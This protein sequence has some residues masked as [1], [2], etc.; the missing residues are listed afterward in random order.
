ML[1]LENFLGIDLTK[2][3][4]ENWLMEG[5]E[6]E[7]NGEFVKIYTTSVDCEELPFFYKCTAKVAGCT[8]T[9]FYFDM[10]FDIMDAHDVAFTIERDLFHNGRYNYNDSISKFGKKLA[11]EFG[12]IVWKYKDITIELR[13]IDEIACLIVWTKYDNSKNIKQKETSSDYIWCIGKVPLTV[14]DLD[15][16]QETFR[17]IS[18]YVVGA[19][20]KDDKL[21]AFE[22]NQRKILFEFISPEIRKLIREGNIVGM[23]LSPDIDESNPHF[24]QISMKTMYFP[25]NDTVEED[26]LE[27]EDELIERK[28]SS[29]SIHYVVNNNDVEKIIKYKN[30]H[31]SV[32]GFQYHTDRDELLDNI[33]IGTELNLIPEPTNPYDPQAIAVYWKETLI[34]YIPRTDIPAIAVN[35]SN[36][37]GKA[38]VHMIGA[39][40][41]GISIEATFERLNSEIAKQ[42]GDFRYSKTIF[43]LY[44]EW[45]KTSFINIDQ[46]EFLELLQKQEKILY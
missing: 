5:V 40:L 17:N 39:N 12:N 21:Y 37:G 15:G 44:E 29:L 1:S 7:K 27:C 11:Q 8:G 38:Y 35:M 19:V 30:V 31:S 24:I 43:E 26:N 36:D 25:I 42:Y 14:K 13:R 23:V 18:N 6:E 33:Q 2:S 28:V 46:K 10:D 20:I 45:D 16:L 9:N 3:P 22:A 34:G 32:V 4:N 41:I